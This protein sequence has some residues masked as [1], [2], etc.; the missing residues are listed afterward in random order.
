MMAAAI[1]FVV[2]SLAML[3]F[4]ISHCRSV[5]AASTARRL[6]DQIWEITGIENRELRGEEFIRLLQLMS[7]CP[8][9]GTDHRALGAIRAYFWMVSFVRATLRGVIP[10]IVSWTDAE[11]SGCARFAAVALDNR[12]SRSRELMAQQFSSQP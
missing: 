1:I 9:S 2:S 10:G 4:F 8:D 3:Q 6:S 5:I 11:L 12:I 7:L